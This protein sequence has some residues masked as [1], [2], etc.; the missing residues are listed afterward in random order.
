MRLNILACLAVLASGCGGDHEI[1]RYV[2]SVQVTAPGAA[3]ELMDHLFVPQCDNAVLENETLLV[4]D[5]FVE[6][7][8]TAIQLVYS[9]IDLSEG[10]QNSLHFFLADDDSVVIAGALN[11]TLDL[12]EIDH[13]GRV[14]LIEAE[15]KGGDI[16]HFYD[17]IAQPVNE[18]H[19]LGKK[20]KIDFVSTFDGWPCV[21]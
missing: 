20:E 13:K 16:E 6:D 11:Q 19:S 14:T 3:P 7:A 17:V 2:I 10:G 15:N 9:G 8:V 1:E 12:Y 4:Y 18:V 21:D 5:G